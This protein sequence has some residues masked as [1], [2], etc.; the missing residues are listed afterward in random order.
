MLHGTIDKDLVELGFEARTQPVTQRAHLLG[1]LGHFLLGQFAGLAEA[2]DAGDIQRAG[3]HTALVAAAIDNGGKLNARVATANIEGT[4]AFGSID[5]VAGDGEQVDIVLLDVDWNFA[6]RLHTIDS[7]DD[8]VFLGNLADFR[9]GIDDANLVV[10]IH[11]GDEN[12]FRRDGFTHVF[13]V[14]AAIALYRQVGDFVAVLFEALAGVEYS[15]VLNGLGDDMVALFA[16]HFRDALDHQVVGLGRTAGKDDFLG[17]GADQRSDLGARVLHR[18]FAGPAERVIAACGVAELLREI[19][20]HR[21]D[22]T[23]VHRGGRVIV[24]VNRQLD[25]HF[26]SPKLA[27]RRARA[28]AALRSSEKSLPC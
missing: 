20:Q 26:L 17:R 28:L 3:T 7:E 19:G 2:D 4:D 23:R 5:L 1:L 18:F 21:V 15:F 13:R 11:D 14:D 16:V 25:S 9:H 12:C 6:N 8:A 27:T 22:N 24:H 10:G